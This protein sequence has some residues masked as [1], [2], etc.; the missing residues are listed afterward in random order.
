MRHERS[1]LRIGQAL[2][3]HLL[4]VLHV[5]DQCRDILPSLGLHGVL[6]DGQ[7]EILKSFQVLLNLVLVLGL[8]CRRS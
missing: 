5:L 8:V 7:E 4:L 6:W 3:S 2:L 1:E